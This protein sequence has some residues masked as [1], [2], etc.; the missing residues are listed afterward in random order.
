MESLK[1]RVKNFNS[2]FLNPKLK[3]SVKKLKIL[4]QKFLKFSVK[5]LILP[6]VSIP[7]PKGQNKL[8]AAE[9]FMSNLQKSEHE[10]HM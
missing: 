9:K 8:T 5:A 7:R 4:L 10:A 2:K 1:T 6:K 3:N